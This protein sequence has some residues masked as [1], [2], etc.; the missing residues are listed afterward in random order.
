MIKRITLIAALCLAL[1]GCSQIFSMARG[2]VAKKDPLISVNT[3]VS[4]IGNKQKVKTVNG[5]VAGRDSIKIFGDHCTVKQ[6]EIQMSTWIFITFLIISLVIAAIAGTIGW[7]LDTP[8]TML[9]RRRKRKEGGR[10]SP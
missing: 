6:G 4:S 7:C 5:H 10:G 8:R 2:I 3:A 1:S 9:E